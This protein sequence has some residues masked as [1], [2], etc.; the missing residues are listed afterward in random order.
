MVERGIYQ[1]C[2]SSSKSMGGDVVDGMSRVGD[3]PRPLGYYA[4][5]SERATVA[6]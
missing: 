6:L 3:Q 1:F 4:G 2:V 5:V